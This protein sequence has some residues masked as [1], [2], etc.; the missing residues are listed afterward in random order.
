MQFRA[1]WVLFFHGRNSDGANFSSL[2]PH[3]LHLNCSLDAPE[4]NEEVQLEGIIT[5][6]TE[7]WAK[8][9]LVNK[10]NRAPRPL[11]CV[12]I[13]VYKPLLCCLRMQKK[14]RITLRWNFFTL[15]SK[16][17]DLSF[18]TTILEYTHLHIDS[19]SLAAWPHGS[20]I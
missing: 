20:N 18:F 8:W 6:I 17:R 4:I 10:G 5:V 9:G 2:F 16:V 15:L 12:S 11:Y 1:F 3:M 7:G 14:I 13:L 19:M